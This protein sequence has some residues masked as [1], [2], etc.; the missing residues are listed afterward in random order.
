MRHEI[1]SARR[2]GCELVSFGESPRRTRIVCPDGW[3]A[4]RLLAELSR[5][6]LAD[7]RAAPLIEIAEELRRA[8]PN[9]ED[10]AR[11]VH[12]FVMRFVRFERE[13]GEIFQHPAVTLATGVGDCECHS[14]LVAA[15][16]RAGGVPARLALF[17]RKGAWTT[18]ERSG[19]PRHVTAQARVGSQWRWLET[20]IRGAR[21]GE[22]PVSS[23]IRTRAARADV[24]PNYGKVIIMGADKSFGVEGG[25][26]YRGRVEIPNHF[27]PATDRVAGG[28]VVKVVRRILEKLGFADV[29]TTTSPAAPRVVAFEALYARP[30]SRMLDE[31]LDHGLRLAFLEPKAPRVTTTLGDVTTERAAVPVKV[32]SLP[33]G[34]VSHV[35]AAPIVVEAWRRVHGRA[36]TRDE[37]VMMMAVASL[38]SN[39][40]RASGQHA[41]W[42]SQG[43]YTW[44]NAEI[45]RKPEAQ[46]P[47]GVGPRGER[48]VPG[49]DAGNARCFRVWPSDVAAA[50]DLVELLT[51]RHW[52]VVAA[53]GQ[54]PEAV[55]QAMKKPPAY[56]EADVAIYARGLRARHDEIR[57]ALAGRNIPLAIVI[58]F[59]IV[60]ALSA[61]ELL[62]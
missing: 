57:R 45:H 30:E 39:Y 23:A 18:V 17:G 20:T 62:T 59:A 2:A 1:E 9:A 54:G 40:G 15:L 29:D 4:A 36:P 55:A 8:H 50:I 28:D 26:N 41:T 11:A 60:A 38:E 52:P 14:R 49:S 43:L 34:R 10:F 44:A 31:E 42:A 27:P 53:M 25:T 16:L 58:P 47:A 12:A 32:E 6:D 48:W 51:K 5:E 35:D 13:R 37:L 19:N 56:Y 24:A 3:A 33:P 21:F 46:C 22:E 61:R 7:G